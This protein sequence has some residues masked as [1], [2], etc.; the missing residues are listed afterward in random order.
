M[1]NAAWCTWL[2]VTSFAVGA[3]SCWARASPTGEKLRSSLASPWTKPPLGPSAIPAGVSTEAV[4]GSAGD[5]AMPCSRNP[6]QQNRVAREIR[7]GMLFPLPSQRGAVR[8][9]RPSMNVASLP[10]LDGVARAS[11]RAGCVPGTVLDRIE[12]DLQA[13][14]IKVSMQVAWSVGGSGTAGPAMNLYALIR[15]T[16]GRLRHGVR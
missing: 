16:D 12:R 2:G 14:E 3:S 11:S 5:S 15:W 6:R 7:F 1:S 13:R 9:A 4:P 10:S 8:A